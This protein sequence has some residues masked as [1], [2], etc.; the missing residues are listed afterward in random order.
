MKNWKIHARKLLNSSTDIDKTIKVYIN[1][2]TKARVKIPS[3]LIDT[4]LTVS[5]NPITPAR[6]R[7]TNLVALQAIAPQKRAA[8]S[9]RPCF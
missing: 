5:V 8:R 9:Y 1:H 3:R 4:Y 2:G 6:S 7:A